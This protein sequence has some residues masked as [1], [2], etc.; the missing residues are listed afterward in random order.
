MM[1]LLVSSVLVSPAAALGAAQQATVADGVYT[2]QQAARGK[3]AYQ[4]ACVACHQDDLT[5]DAFA[6][7]LIGETFKQRWQD[8]DVGELFTVV[9][10]TMPQTKPGELS[11][12]QYA[13]IIAYLLLMNSHPAGTH[14]LGTKPETLSKITFKSR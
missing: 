12:E 11:D 13:D 6:T 14:E 8:S 2:A 1:A 7:P 9:K 3:A 5:G 4:S 10:G